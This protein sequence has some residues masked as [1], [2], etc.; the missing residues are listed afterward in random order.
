MDKKKYI[1]PTS[2]VVKLKIESL[3]VNESMGVDSS[4]TVTNNNQ[5]YS[6]RGK[7]FDDDE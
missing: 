5:V 2:I 7:S 4:H 6:R 3:L 1:I